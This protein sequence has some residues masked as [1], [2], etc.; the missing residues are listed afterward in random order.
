MIC[1]ISFNKFPDVLSALTY[2]RTFANLCSIYLGLNIWSCEQK[3]PK[4]RLLPFHCLFKSRI[5]STIS[6]I[7]LEFSFSRIAHII[8]AFLKSTNASLILFI[9][10]YYC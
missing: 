10:I 6:T 8:T 9:L 3:T 4:G 1:L 7:L 2:A 5:F